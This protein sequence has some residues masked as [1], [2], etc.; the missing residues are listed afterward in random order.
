MECCTY[1]HI[2]G[3]MHISIHAQYSCTHITIVHALY[4]VMC[5]YI[6]GITQSLPSNCHAL[7]HY[8]L[9][10]CTCTL[11]MCNVLYIHIFPVW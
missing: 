4:T 5:M 9:C 1:R 8:T 11:S 6:G 3:Y 7:T 10:T 2:Q